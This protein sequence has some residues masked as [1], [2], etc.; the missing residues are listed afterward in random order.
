MRAIETIPDEPPPELRYRRRVRLGAALRDLWRSRDLVRTLAERDIRA[1]YKQAVLGFAWAILNPLILVVAFTIL[2]DRVTDLDTG[3]LPYPVFSYVA[4]LGWNFFQTGATMGMTSLINNLSLLNKMPCPREVFP[5]AALVGSALDGIVAVLLLPLLL[6]VYRTAPQATSP[7]ALLALPAL[8]L[9]T[10]AVAYIS[11]AIV[12]YLRDLRHGFAMLM[13]LLLFATPVAYGI[14]NLPRVWRPVVQIGNPI[15]TVIETSR[16]TILLGQA[17]AWG[18]LGGA[19]L[20][21]CVL[22]LLS[23]WAFKRL[24]TGIADVA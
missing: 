11:A 10:A 1:R 2:F 14:R 16:R 23:Y 21:A 6:L 24:E 8:V 9:T 17:P 13:Q 20:V 18:Y 7:L 4:L 22:F 15:A 3:G 12:V 19:T 5:S